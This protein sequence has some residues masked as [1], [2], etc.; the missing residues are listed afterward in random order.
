M[1]NDRRQYDH[2]QVIHQIISRWDGETEQERYFRLMALRDSIALELVKHRCADCA[3]IKNGNCTV[4]NMAISEEHRYVEN[5]CTEYLE[6][7]PF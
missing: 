1:S 4:Y 7:I 6:I 5:P 3:Y 2:S